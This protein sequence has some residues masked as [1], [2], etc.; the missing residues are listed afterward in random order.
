MF[1]QVD[2][3]RKVIDEQVD[4]IKK[5]IEGSIQPTISK[6]EAIKELGTI[7]AL[8]IG[9]YDKLE[10]NELKAEVW[11]LKEEADNTF[12]KLVGF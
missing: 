8:V 11:S 6:H 10:D 9:L 12:Q 1:I 7:S 4:T 2:L 5:Q 3:L